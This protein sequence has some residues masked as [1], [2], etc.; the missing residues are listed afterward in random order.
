M[1]DF[2]PIEVSGQIKPLQGEPKLLVAIQW[3]NRHGSARYSLAFQNAFARPRNAA[4]FLSPLV[5]SVSHHGHAAFAA[6]PVL[7]ALR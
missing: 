4:H 5:L 6:P 7:Q 2:P 1:V 3:W